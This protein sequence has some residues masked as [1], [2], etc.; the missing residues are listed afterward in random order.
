MKVDLW[1]G[2]FIGAMVLG[3]VYIAQTGARANAVA[4][5]DG[6]QMCQRDLT[7]FVSFKDPQSVRV[8]YIK[9][10]PNRE[11]RYE[12]SVSAKNSFGGYADATLCTC[13]TKA[14]AVTDLHCD[15]PSGQ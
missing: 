4:P 6:A 8:N 15:S 10:N 14:G 5:V 12:M 11:G 13:G 7:S 3:V 1:G 2:V 9:P